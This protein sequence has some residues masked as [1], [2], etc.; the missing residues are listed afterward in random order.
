VP[1]FDASYTGFVNGDTASVLSGLTCSALDANGNPV[2]SATLAGTA[3]FTGY[4]HSDLATVGD[5]VVIGAGALHLA[6][7][8]EAP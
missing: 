4:C 8:R 7:P 5:D 2:S 3:L 6:D 1:A